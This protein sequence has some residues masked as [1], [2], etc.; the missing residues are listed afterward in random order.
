MKLGKHNLWLLVPVLLFTWGLSPDGSDQ[1]QYTKAELIGDFNPAR[2]PDFDRLQSRYTNRGDAYLREEVYDAF[3]EMHKAAR[4]DG[5]ELTVISATRNKDYQSN[6]WNRK[7]ERYSG[8]DE[9]RAKRILEYSSMPGTSRHHWGTDFDLNALE[10]SYFES[11][12]GLAVYQWLQENAGTFGF[13]QPYT[14][15]NSYRNTGY[16]MEKWHW[17]YY[18]T[19]QKMQR[20]YRFLIQPLDLNGFKGSYLAAKLNVI[21]EYVL[22]IEV[23]EELWEKP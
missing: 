9:E 4:K 15:A 10:N 13:F 3:K 20:A 17:S 6:I 8:S 12:K 16:R 23:P 7:W 22:G 14:K 21:D 19:A 11:G 18:P 5:I 2:H 1:P